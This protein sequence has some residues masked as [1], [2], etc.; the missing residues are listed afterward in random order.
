LKYLFAAVVTVGALQV[1]L[2]ESQFNQPAFDVVSVKS[3]P[4][5]G[6]N[7]GNFPREFRFLAGGRDFEMIEGAVVALIRYAYP[8][9]GNEVQGIPDWVLSERYDVKA[10]TVEAATVPR[11]RAMVGA[12]LASRF[13]FRFH[14]ETVE[15]PVYRLVRAR[16]DGSLDPNL[17]KSSA[18]CSALRAARERGEQPASPPQ[19]GAQLC[20]MGYGSG[21]LFARGIPMADLA[22]VISADAGRVVLDATNLEGDFEFLLEWDPLP[23]ADRQTNRTSLFVALEE[24]L[25]LKLQTDRAP[26]R[27]VSVDRIE[28]PAPD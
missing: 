6:R 17:K 26:V 7:I 14:Y 15:Q 18:D 11:R 10:R 24:Q 5:G 27:I 1:T 22:A 19:P 3:N 4:N 23:L 9:L 20:S 21:S 16:A 8:T 25:G 13:N 2:A 28:R 12:L